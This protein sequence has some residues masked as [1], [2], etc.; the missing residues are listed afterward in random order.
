MERESLTDAASPMRGVCE[1]G[2]Y[3]SSHYYDTSERP[4][5]AAGLGRCRSTVTT[6][7][8]MGDTVTPCQCKA[9]KEAA[10]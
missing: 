7:A 2:H 8:R 10:R 4:N 3:R 6:T 1:C 9:F 5:V